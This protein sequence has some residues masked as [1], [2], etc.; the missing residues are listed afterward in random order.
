VHAS[1]AFLRYPGKMFCEKMNCLVARRIRNSSS[2][3][4]APSRL[5]KMNTEQMAVNLEICSSL[6]WA[7]AALMKQSPLG[8]K[9]TEIDFWSGASNF[10][11]QHAV[12]ALLVSKP[13]HTGL[14]GRMTLRPAQ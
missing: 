11:S 1:W 13:K 2:S 10:A 4:Q 12:L 9:A 6:P 7:K 3:A 5:R 8:I 14:L